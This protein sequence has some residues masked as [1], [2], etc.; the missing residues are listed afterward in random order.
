MSWFLRVTLDAATP[1]IVAI[2]GSWI[3][4]LYT[5]LT[6]KKLEAENR[7][8]L[9]TVLTNVAGG[10]IQRGL[11]HSTPTSPAVT[12][13]VAKVEARAPDAI[14]AFPQLKEPGVIAGKVLEKVGLEMAKGQK[15]EPVTPTYPNPATAPGAQ[16][17][18][19]FGPPRG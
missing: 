16:M 11:S 13:A 9:E 6:N 3:A 15:I 5:K 19:Y 18:G 12:E 8:S 4:V 2:I 7:A 14:E 1:V 10:L 17:G